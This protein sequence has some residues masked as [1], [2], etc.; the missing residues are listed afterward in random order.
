MLGHYNR[1]AKLLIA[2]NA[3][4][5]LFLQFSIF[6]MPFYLS[7][8]GYGMDKMGIFFSIQTFAG[9]LF[10][11]IAGQV[12]LK[13]G[14]K[15]TLILG[16]LLGLM[17]RILQVLALN[18]YVIALG[19]FLIGAN[20]GIRQPNFYAL[21]SEEVEEKQRHHAFSISF[22]IGTIL[23]ALGVLIAG[24]APDFFVETFGLS[25]ELAYRL[26][27]SLAILQFAIV[28]PILLIIKDVPVKNPRINWRKELVVKILKFSLPSAMIGLGAGITI[29]YMSLYFNLRFG[30][31]L[32]TI[33]GVFFAQQLVMGISSFI[34]PKLVNKIGP[35]KTISLFQSIAAFLF[36]IFPSLELFLLAAF[37]YIIRSIL[38]NI[39]WPIDDA[40]MMGFF[41][42][43]E[44]ATAA[45]IRRAFST[46]MRG[47]GNYIGGILFSISLSYPFYATATLYVAATLIFYFFFVKYNRV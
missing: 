13:L 37:V 41:T 10:F 7:A 5:Q 35:V 34:L 25:R 19:F 47:V 45:G 26:V 39:V 16:A 4:G 30:Q 9:G 27:V 33:S 12:S 42:T 46:F 43:E 40:F 20:M 11:L 29:P 15:R 6:I 31:T 8:L 23:N 22:G 18:F 28:I 1:D 17:G 36:G 21:L 3:A 2:A 44:K 24:F 32:A 14:Y 38:M